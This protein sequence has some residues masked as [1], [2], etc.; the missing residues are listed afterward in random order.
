MCGRLQT[1]KA[2]PFLHARGETEV[3]FQR[4]RKVG[5]RYDSQISEKYAW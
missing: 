4:F 3:R 2:S 1:E 5:Q